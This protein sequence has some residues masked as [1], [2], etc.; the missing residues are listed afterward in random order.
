MDLNHRRTYDCDH[1]AESTGAATSQVRAVLA[2]VL[3]GLGDLGGQVLTMHSTRAALAWSVQSMQTQPEYAHNKTTGE[4]GPTGRYE[5]TITL[6]VLVRDFALLERVSAAMTSEDAVRV[7]SVSWSV[8]ED[9]G[10]WAQ[11]RAD[12]IRAALLK[13]QDYAAALG[14]RIIRVDHVADA[15]LLGCDSGGWATRT[16]GVALSAM[17]SSGEGVSLDPVPQVLHAT[18]EARFTAEVSA[19]PER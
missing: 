3:V 18:I 7:H 9:N 14:G 16:R 12:A 17:G 10:E 11:V 5:S 4:S 8:D 2:G 6:Q 19:V 1:L 15:G 13:G